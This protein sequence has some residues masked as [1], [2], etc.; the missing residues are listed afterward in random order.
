[1][2]G[3]HPQLYGFPELHLFLADTVNELLDR[4][5]K[6]GNY[7]GSPGILRTLAQL[8]EGLQSTSSIIR[9]GAWL[10]DRRHWSVKELIDYLLQMISPRLGVE[11]S[12]VTCKSQ[13]YLARAYACYPKAHYLHLTRHPIST[14]LSMEEFFQNRKKLRILRRK[15]D[16]MKDM[17]SLE[18]KYNH[19]LVW[20]V[21]HK[22]IL[23]FTSNLPIG[24]VMRIKGEEI[25]S[26]PDMY[27]PQIAEW[28]GINT[29]SAS[30]EEMKHPERSP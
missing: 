18:V 23:N 12:P 8:H 26:E 21:F 5:Q 25:L 3:Q 11:K 9:A 4:E 17:Q 28:L 27:L 14:K 19:L 22:N 20:Y 24:Q 6:K 30:I 13:S 10:A 16:E 1:M 15:T 2:I 7:C 29:D